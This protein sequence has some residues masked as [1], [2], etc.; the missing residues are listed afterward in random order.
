MSFI[1]EIP[2][3]SKHVYIELVTGSHNNE[4]F[5]HSGEIRFPLAVNDK[6]EEHLEE[7]RYI[8]KASTLKLVQA[9]PR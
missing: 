2:Q 5:D 7:E 6:H 9:A 3:E 4:L 1:Y 8:L